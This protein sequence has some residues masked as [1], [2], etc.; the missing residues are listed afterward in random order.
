MVAEPEGKCWRPKNKSI[1][2]SLTHHMDKCSFACILCKL[3]SMLSG[4]VIKIA[5]FLRVGWIRNGNNHPHHSGYVASG[6]MESHTRETKCA[7]CQHRYPRKLDL[8]QKSSHPEKH[9]TP[10]PGLTTAPGRLSFLLG[11]P[12]LLA[13]CIVFR[14]GPI[15]PSP[16]VEI[17]IITVIKSLRTN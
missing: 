2:A 9:M 8:K 3:R 17:I 12:N 7:A 15:L 14:A 16:G 5:A 10:N 1:F 13:C 4:Y 6:R 11:K